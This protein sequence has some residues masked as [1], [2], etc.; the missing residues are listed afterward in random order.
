M[1][2]R[3]A[4]EMSD[5]PADWSEIGKVV[6]IRDEIAPQTLI[7]G[8]GDVNSY[9]QAL[10]LADRYRVDGTMIARH[11]ILF[12]NVSHILVSH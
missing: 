12:S 4:K 5:V 1:H 9:Q 10:E 11:A 8:N 7:V 6:K 2:G 3:T